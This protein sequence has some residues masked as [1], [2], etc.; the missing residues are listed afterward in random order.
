[1]FTWI[2]LLF[3]IVAFSTYYDVDF[4]CVE[5]GEC[6][7][8]TSQNIVSEFTNLSLLGSFALLIVCVIWE[9]SIKE[10]KEI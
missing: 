8:A 9:K 2:T 1:M 4:V 5:D 3:V 7:T 10:T 6:Y